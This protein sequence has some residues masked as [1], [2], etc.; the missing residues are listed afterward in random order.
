MI[1]NRSRHTVV[2]VEE[3]KCL[4]LIGGSDEH[5][6]LSQCELYDAE[7]DLYF[8]FPS[9]NIARENAS[10]CVFRDTRG[11]LWVYVFGGFN[12]KPID[13]I[14]RIQLTF[15]RQGRH[16]VVVSKWERLKDATMLRS[17]E[18]C[19]VTQFSENEIV[20]FGGL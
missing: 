8:A 3:H 7:K 9:T 13:D 12:K 18:C 2:A 4:V 20:I 15:G 1:K 17:V 11:Q 16:Q 6:P 14:E 19:G 5:T 10:S